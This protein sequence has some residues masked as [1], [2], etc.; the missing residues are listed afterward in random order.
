M[1]LLKTPNNPDLP[2]FEHPLYAARRSNLVELRALFSGTRAVRAARELF[3]P[4]HPKEDADDYTRRVLGAEVYNGFRRT[5][6]AMTGLVFQREIVLSDAGI[7]EDG[8]TTDA[9]DDSFAHAWEDIDGAGTHGDVFAK[10]AFTDALTTGVGG[11]LVDYPNAEGVRSHAD[12]LARGLRPYWVYY[13]REQI[14]SWRFASVDGRR[15]LTQLVLCE[16]VEEPVGRFGVGYA[17]YYRVFRRPVL[18][19]TDANGLEVTQASDVIEWEVWK[20]PPGRDTRVEFQRS[21]TLGQAKRIPFAFVVLAPDPDDLD[22]DPPL[23][24]LADVNIAHFK[25][26]A[27]RRHL[28][29]IACVPIPVRTGLV[30][31]FTGVDGEKTTGEMAIG[32]NLLQDLPKD[33]T[34]SWAEVS[35]T[36]FAPTKEEKDDLERQMGS[37]GWAFLSSETRAAETAE[38]KR[39]DSAAQNATLADCVRALKDALENAAAIHMEYRGVTDD[40]SLPGFTVNTEFESIVGDSAFVAAV[41]ALEAAGQLSLDTLWQ[42]LTKARVLP[43]DF[44]PEEEKKRIAARAAQLDIDDTSEDDTD[45]DDPPAPAG[46]GKKTPGG[47]P[48]APGAPAAGK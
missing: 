30:G 2:D 5:I 20:K 38:A 27:D 12:E 13:A 31:G 14:I 35:G 15:I 11:I 44:D 23:Q 9:P 6:R 46:A 21:G 41:S 10:A 29:H 4:R 47:S 45:D 43:D 16:T 26:T 28:M 7:P 18:Q 22:A 19:T 39:I 24:D 48:K 37:L 36:G 33:G 25:I 42:L 3:L 17:T 40:A 32:P 1:T 34:F 8:D